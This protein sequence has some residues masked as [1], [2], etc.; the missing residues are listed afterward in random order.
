MDWLESSPEYIGTSCIDS[1]CSI[2]NIEYG[3]EVN[4]INCGLKTQL[5]AH[6]K[7]VNSIAFSN[8]ESAREQFATASEDGSVRLFDARN[9]QHSTILY[10]DPKKR[11]LNHIAWNKQDPFIIAILPH[12][13]TE[14]L[15]IDIRKLQTRDS[16]T[17]NN[18][19]SVINSMAWAPHSPIHICTVGIDNQ[20]LIWQTDRFPRE[21]PILAYK[22]AGEICQVKWSK[23]Q[24]EWISIVFGNSI[25]VLR[26]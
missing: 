4:K 15:M 11:P 1:T 17:Y 3:V 9:L 18:H 12:G 26:V 14:V 24:S 25:E 19:N 2:W 23:A 22:A 13:S 6:E 20:A 7:S 10:D 16:T 8:L 5:I 21:E